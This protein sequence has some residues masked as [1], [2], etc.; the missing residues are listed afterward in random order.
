MPKNTQ[1]ASWEEWKARCALDLC[2]PE[3]QA[4]LAGFV[5]PILKA[6]IRRNDPY[7]VIS[8]RRKG[9]DTQADFFHLFES[10]MHCTSSKTGKRWKD[11]LFQVTVRG[12]DSN[13]TAIERTVCSCL[14]SVAAK[15]CLGE[16]SGRSR[17]AKANQISLDEPVVEGGDPIGEGA[18]RGRPDLRDCPL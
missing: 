3:T 11:W 10:Y 6:K 13:E 5:G 4:E 14:R 17:K 2:K 9:G 16:G 8:P 18:R 7:M 12:T 15:F 1:M